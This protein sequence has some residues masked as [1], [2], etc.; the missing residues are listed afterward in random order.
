MNDFCRNDFYAKHRNIFS[1][2]HAVKS[3]RILLCG[4]ENGGC[5]PVEL[6]ITVDTYWSKVT[7]AQDRR[8]T[9]RS[10]LNIS[11]PFDQ[12]SMAFKSRNVN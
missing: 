12:V 9:L 8:S 2:A 6:S 5:E 4:D 10:I 7:S 3:T 11:F 1:C